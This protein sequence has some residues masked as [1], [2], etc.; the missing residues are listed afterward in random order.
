MSK[1]VVDQQRYNVV[2]YNLGLI[3]G[4]I[5]VVLASVAEEVVNE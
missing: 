5:K 2:N 4:K 3:S 1:F